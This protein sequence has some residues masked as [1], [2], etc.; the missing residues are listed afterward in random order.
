M[1]DSFLVGI[2][3]DLISDPIGN[4]AAMFT[5]VNLKYIFVTM[6]IVSFFV[7]SFGNLKQRGKRQMKRGMTSWDLD[8]LKEIAKKGIDVKNFKRLSEMDVENITIT[9][10]LINAYYKY[11]Y[12]LLEPRTEVSA[13]RVLS[14]I[15]PKFDDPFLSD[16]R[17][18]KIHLIIWFLAG[19]RCS[20]QSSKRRF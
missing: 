16:F 7:T 9:N 3:G 8:K 14:L 1:S 17:S 18:Y 4:A 10:T 5:F 12:G 6:L 11:T 15:S 19:Q 20:A 2:L 13:I